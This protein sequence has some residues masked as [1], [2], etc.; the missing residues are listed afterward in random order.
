MSFTQFSPNNSSFARLLDEKFSDSVPNED[1]TA[2]RALKALHPGK[3]TRHVALLDNTVCPAFPLSAYLKTRDVAIELVQHP[4]HELVQWNASA[5]AGS[6]A[7]LHFF[8]LQNNVGAMTDRGELSS[9]LI[10]GSLKFSYE[11]T[12]F[13][14]YKVS[15]RSLYGQQTSLFD[16]VFEDPSSDAS[17]IEDDP[18]AKLNTVGHNLVRDVYRWAGALKDEMWV[19]QDGRWSKDKAMWAAIRDASWNDIILEKEFLE[20]LRRDTRTFF[21]NRKIYKDLGVI[22]KR[23]LLLLG[24]PGNGKTESIKVLLKESGQAALYVKSF[25]TQDVRHL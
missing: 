8:A 7:G 24:P 25:T 3:N 6:A 10:T 2:L 12:E 14:V 1:L 16:L 13:L 15:W 18:E 4:S 11:G 9:R 19:F 5:G 22:W 21:E 23:G 20:G 17:V